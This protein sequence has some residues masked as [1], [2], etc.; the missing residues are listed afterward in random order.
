MLVIRWADP[1]LEVPVM[2]KGSLHRKKSKVIIFLSGIISL[3]IAL[4][5]AF[6][7]LSVLL[8]GGLLNEKL[9]R[10][11]LSE[12][13]YFDNKI[14]EVRQS[15]SHKLSL[16]G[17]PD[18]IS[19]DVITGTAITIDA[20][21][22]IKYG[23][24]DDTDGMSQFG[25]TLRENIYEY[26]DETG[27]T[28][29]DDVKKSVELIVTEIAKDYDTH[30]T[31]LFARLYNEFHEKYDHI[32]DIVIYVSIAVLILCSVAAVLLHSRKY[33]GLRYVG[34]G[35]LAGSV[36]TETVS[37][38]MKFNLKGMMP[39][40]KTEYY[41]FINTFIDK[42]FSQGIYMCLAGMLLFSLVALTTYYLKK[43]A[44]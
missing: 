3:F 12:S 35:I 30:M 22:K 2:S 29:T 16:A 37:V 17:L 38:I 26:L 32:F 19:E 20:N 13:T 31:F 41:N 7:L 27:V 25:D 11:T 14:D 34:Y 9:F 33:R 42:S 4:C 6:I 1:L 24:P 39:D 10:Q 40:N 43:Q 5:M 23:R 44:I 15:V 18:E 36:V 28:V 21:K 8:K